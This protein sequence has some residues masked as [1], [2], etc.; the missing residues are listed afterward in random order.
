MMQ[1][2]IEILDG[3]ILKIAATIVSC[4]A[5]FGTSEG[6]A[7]TVTLKIYDSVI[8]IEYY[9]WYRHNREKMHKNAKRGS[10]GVCFFVSKE[11]NN[12]YDIEI[13]D[14]TTEGILWICV[15]HQRYTKCSLLLCMCMLPST[16]GIF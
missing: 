6:G 2:V 11:L 5:D 9:M 7:V 3:V 13:I 1:I 15:K 14:K 12:Y 10:G 8:N 4:P 16:T